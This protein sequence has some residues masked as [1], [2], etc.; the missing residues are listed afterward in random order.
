MVL[1]RRL[2]LQ[3]GR[4]WCF[5]LRLHDGAFV[6]VLRGDGAGSRRSTRQAMG[7]SGHNARRG[8][9]SLLLRRLY[10]IDRDWSHGGGAE[11]AEGAERS[12]LEATPR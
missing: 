9:T 5:R 8:A 10:G 4:R 7:D 2:R 6:R 11:D 12:N 3:L 1:V